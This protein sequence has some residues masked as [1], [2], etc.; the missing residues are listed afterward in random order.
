MVD[1]GMIDLNQEM[2]CGTDQPPVNDPGTGGHEPGMAGDG[3][4]PAVGGPGMMVDAPGTMVGPGPPEPWLDVPRGVRLVPTPEGLIDPSVLGEHPLTNRMPIKPEHEYEALEESIRIH[5]L[6]QPLIR[7]EGKV[8]DGRHRLRACKELGIPVAVLDFVGS[9]E[10]ALVYV[11]Q[12]N[13]YHHDYGA[14]QRAAVA[15]MLMPDVSEM[16]AQ[17]RLEKVRAAWDAKRAGGCSQKIGNNLGTTDTRTRSH[18]IVGQMMRVNHAYVEHAL[19]IQ[20]DAPELFK[21]LHAGTITMQAAIKKLDGESDDVQ[22]QEIKAARSEFNQ[23]LRNLNRYPDF[24]K[25][26]RAFMAGFGE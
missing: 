22:Q 4:G 9:T 15:A 24:L 25:R 13:Q 10:D 7:F 8:L 16:V 21:Q 5:G 20:R 3:P 23:A 17:G 26:F 11:L 19:R 2:Q 6:Q 18:A 1:A 12:A 14:G